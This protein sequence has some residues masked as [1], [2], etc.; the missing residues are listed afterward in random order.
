MACYQR[1]ALESRGWDQADFVFRQMRAD[2]RGRQIAS[3]DGQQGGPAGLRD[4][5]EDVMSRKHVTRD[6]PD[7]LHGGPYCR[8]LP[9]LAPMLQ[10]RQQ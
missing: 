8:T 2:L 3:A 4:V 10:R 9:L 1:V 5:I 7:G 6:A